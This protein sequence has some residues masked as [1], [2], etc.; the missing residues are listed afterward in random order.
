MKKYEYI[1]RPLQTT[2][3]LNTLGKKGWELV[4]VNQNLYI[5]KKEIIE[6]KTKTK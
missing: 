6:V 1:A 5:F 4:C 3:H 2:E